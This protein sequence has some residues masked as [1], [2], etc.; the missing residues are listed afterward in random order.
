MCFDSIIT[1]VNSLISVPV[2]GETNLNRVK[3][4]VRAKLKKRFFCLFE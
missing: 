4:I 3:T 2:T 1:K